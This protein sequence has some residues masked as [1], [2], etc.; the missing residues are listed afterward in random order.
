MRPA[1]HYRALRMHVQHS[2]PGLLYAA[3]YAI[4]KIYRWLILAIFVFCYSSDPAW[5]AINGNFLHEFN[6]L[7]GSSLTGI[8]QCDK[9][10]QRNISHL[11]K[12]VNSFTAWID[13]W[14]DKSRVAGKI[15]IKHVSLWQGWRSFPDI[16][17]LWI[18]HAS[19]ITFQLGANLTKHAK[20]VALNKRKLYPWY[21]AYITYDLLLILLNTSHDRGNGTAY[22]FFIIAITSE[23]ILKRKNKMKWLI[24]NIFII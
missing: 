6:L 11:I 19:V 2:R 15:I 10:L 12:P 4:L 21:F 9:Y 13:D 16:A 3:A 17:L 24:G 18:W 22:W 7:I 23:L 5:V 14:P 20:R 8:F 1:V